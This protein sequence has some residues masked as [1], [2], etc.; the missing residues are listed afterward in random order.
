MPCLTSSQKKPLELSSALSLVVRK[1]K[2]AFVIMLY[3][4]SIIEARCRKAEIRNN[5]NK[6]FVIT[7]L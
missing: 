3:K 2:E 6:L 1:T 4:Y 7:S 5:K